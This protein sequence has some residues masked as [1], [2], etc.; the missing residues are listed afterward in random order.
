MLERPQ[1]TAIDEYLMGRSLSTEAAARNALISV[2]TD[3]DLDSVIED[4]NVSEPRWFFWSD[5]PPD[6]QGVLDLPVFEALTRLFRRTPFYQDK[7][8]LHP[9]VSFPDDHSAPLRV[10]V[11]RVDSYGQSYRTTV[12]F[13][14]PDLHGVLEARQ[15]LEQARR[16]GLLGG[17]AAT[18][19]ITKID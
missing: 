1:R 19:S 7:D 3:A 10:H 2:K 5:P 6:T 12:F 18:F 14:I 11:R 16:L 4:V 13:D 17:T 8:A 9:V 15:D